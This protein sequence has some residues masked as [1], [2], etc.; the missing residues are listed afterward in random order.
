MADQDVAWAELMQRNGGDIAASMLEV[1]S[2]APMREGRPLS[3]E[4]FLDGVGVI[5]SAAW[6]FAKI[7]D[8]DEDGGRAAR[9]ASLLRAHANGIEAL[10]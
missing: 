2:A 4:D 10:G 3:S 9:Y 8:S 5:L 7:A 6:Q 1:I